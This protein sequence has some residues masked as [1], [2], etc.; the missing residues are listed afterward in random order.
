MYKSLM[1][2]AAAA[3]AMTLLPAA[4]TL[5]ADYTDIASYGPEFANPPAAGWSYAWNAAGTISGDP[6]TY[7]S[8]TYDA[9]NSRYS[10]VG[11]PAAGNLFL[12]ASNA[13]PGPAAAQD[14]GGVERYAIVTYTISAADIAAAG[15]G[16]LQPYLSAYNFNPGSSQDGINARVYVNGELFGGQVIALPPGFAFNDATFGAPYALA[17][18]PNDVTQPGDTITFAIGASGPATVFAGAPGNDVNDLSDIGFTIALGPPV[19]E[20]TAVAALGLTGVA[21]LARRRRGVR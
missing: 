4:A 1:L 16:N 14:A 19:P 8:L 2:S 21:L 11:N 7:T 15:G 6:S 5:A 17:S 10:V 12:S 20:P 18:D 13:Y 3:T 9:V